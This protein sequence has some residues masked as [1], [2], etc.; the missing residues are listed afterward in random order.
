MKQLIS[1]QDRRV[2]EYDEVLVRKYIKEILI[3]EEKIQVVF[4]SGIEV[5]IKRA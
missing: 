1:N 5:D 4:K 2:T 3:Y